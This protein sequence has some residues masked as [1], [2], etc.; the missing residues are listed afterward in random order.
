VN[1]ARRLLVSGVAVT[2]LLALVALASRAHRPGGG[3]G[4]GGGHIPALVGTYLGVTMFV[5]MLL[6]A[7][8]FGVGFASGRRKALLEGRTNWRRTLFAITAV[9]AALL[10][11]LALS[12]RLRP[13]SRRVITAP[14]ALQGNQQKLQKRREDRQPREPNWLTFLIVGSVVLGV[15]GAA[16]LAVRHRRQ[17]GDELEAEAALSRAL[18]EVLADTLDDLRAE[19]D[20]RNAVISTYA[21]MERTFAAYRVPRDPA[22]TPLEYVA[23]ALESLSVSGHAVRRLTLLFERAKFS[24]HSV[25]AG[26]KDDAIETLASLRGELEAAHE[27]AAA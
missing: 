8:L 24:T 10:L 20:P 13:N 27:E 11:A 17:D 14:V 15:A 2:A 6:A 26:M 21:R 5:L 18:D 12:S 9:A 3:T 23:R 25:D 7:V 16:A 4:G 19:R 22:E 1:G